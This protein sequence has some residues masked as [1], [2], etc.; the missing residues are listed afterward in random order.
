MVVKRVQGASDKLF[1]GLGRAAPA[2]VLRSTRVS[3]EVHAPVVCLGGQPRAA[4]ARTLGPLA[5]L[6]TDPPRRGFEVLA[7]E[8]GIAALPWCSSSLNI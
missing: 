4:L 5:S 3:M 7:T 6:V 8:D 1:L 2:L